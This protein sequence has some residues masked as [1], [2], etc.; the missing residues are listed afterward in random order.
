MS[1]TAEWYEEQDPDRFSFHTGE[2]VVS[3]DPA[4]NS[5]T[6]DKGRT[7]KYNH[8]VLATGSEATLPLYADLSIPGVFVYRNISDV[9]Q[10]MAYTEQTN[11]KHLSVR[12]F[13][14]FARLRWLMLFPSSSY[15]SHRCHPF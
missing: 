3:L 10:I 14:H 4:A 5:A 2:K 8:C 13:S 12:L 6:T 15:L 9:S 1:S 7:I 11:K